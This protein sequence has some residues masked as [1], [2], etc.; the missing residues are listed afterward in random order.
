VPLARAAHLVG[1]AP[2]G[3]LPDV[4]VAMRGGR[5]SRRICRVAAGVLDGVL[6]RPEL[7]LSTGAW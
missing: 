7:M 5:I 2:L 6:A 4:P 3:R 1:A